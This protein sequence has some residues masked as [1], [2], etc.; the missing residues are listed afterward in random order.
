MGNYKTKCGGRTKYHE[1]GVCVDL[2]LESIFFFFFFGEKGYE[3]GGST[4]TQQ[5]TV[6]A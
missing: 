4:V 2:Y 5:Y 6:I 3:L 1:E